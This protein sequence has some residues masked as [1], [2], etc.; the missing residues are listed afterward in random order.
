VGRE[1]SEQT[2][3]E[4][5]ELAVAGCM[6]LGRNGYKVSILR[7]LVSRALFASSGGRGEGP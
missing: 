3:R 6:P 4:A 1:L 2:G 5:A 7:A